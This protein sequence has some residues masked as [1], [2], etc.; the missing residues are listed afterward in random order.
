MAS[1]LKECVDNGLLDPDIQY[2]LVNSI[3]KPS[4]R[5]KPAEKKLNKYS[6]FIHLVVENG[7]F[8]ETRFLPNMNNVRYGWFFDTTGAGMSFYI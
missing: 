5:V 6:V 4:L 1:K 2:A 7:T 3:D 8:K